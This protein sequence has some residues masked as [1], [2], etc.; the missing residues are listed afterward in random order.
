M[1]S[2]VYGCVYVLHLKRWMV[3]KAKRAGLLAGAQAHKHTHNIR[4][5]VCEY[6]SGCVR[7]VL[8][9]ALMPK[10]VIKFYHRSSFRNYEN[11]YA[12]F[13]LHIWVVTCRKAAATTTTTITITITFTQNNKIANLISA[14][15]T[16]THTCVWKCIH[17]HICDRV[18]LTFMPTIVMNWRKAEGCFI[19][20]IYL[21]NMH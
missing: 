9:A 13:S 2:L 8:Y 14:S 19:L 21:S 4:I 7:R 16:H 11:F 18:C 5:F 6:V 12:S 1:Q 15:H 10:F 3:C 20:E 17:L